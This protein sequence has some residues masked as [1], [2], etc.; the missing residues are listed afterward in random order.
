MNS[1]KEQLM[2]AMT[3]YFG[4]DTKRIDHALNVTNYAERLLEQE[5]GDYQIVIAAAVLHDIGI[6]EAER[7]YN[8]SSGKYQQIEGPPVAREILQRLE[9]DPARIDQACNIIAY[10]HSVGPMR[11]NRNFCILY[12]ADWLINLPHEYDIRDKDKLKTIIDN[13]FLTQSGRSMAKH[14]YLKNSEL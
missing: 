7:K 5:G 8:S 4:Q 14:I 1:I 13:I 2:N 12:D 11:D 3:A 6:H 9:F 10:N